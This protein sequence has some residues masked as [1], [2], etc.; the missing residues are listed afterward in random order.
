MSTPTLEEEPANNPAT[1][2]F[3]D[4]TQRVSCFC[5]RWVEK[6]QSSSLTCPLRLLLPHSFVKFS[7]SSKKEKDRSFLIGR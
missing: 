5:S 6:R 7:S 1:W 2:D 4:P 3:V